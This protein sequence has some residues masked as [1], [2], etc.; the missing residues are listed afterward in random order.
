MKIKVF[1]S[2]SGDRSK[3]FGEILREWLPK[4]VHVR[5]FFSPE[6]TAKGSNWY[7]EIISELGQ[8]RIGII[9]ITSDN[10]TAPWLMFEA[11]AISK[12]LARPKVCPILFGMSATSLVGP[13]ATFQATEFA[14]DEMMRLVCMINDEAGDDKLDQKTL[15]EVFDT[16]W[17][18]LDAPVKRALNRPGKISTAAVPSRADR[19]ILEEILVRTRSIGNQEKEFK[20]R[21]YSNLGYLVGERSTQPGSLVAKDQD[22]LAEAV[23][24]CQKGWDYLKEIGGAPEFMALNNLVYYSTILNDTSKADFL[25]AQAYR[26]LEAGEQHAATHLILTG[27]FAIIRFSLVLEERRAAYS[28]ILTLSQGPLSTAQ[29]EEAELY[30][31]S[32][33]EL[34]P[35]PKRRI[36]ADK[37]LS[38]RR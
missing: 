18:K 9:C 24:H 35:K 12:S 38:K 21:L 28:K 30:L 20:G 10:L 17:P 25:L 7:S 2:W 5:P 36:S 15:A 13:L 3:V 16:W 33:L 22:L 23:G 29:R 26:L 14:R 31:K 8:A 4:V 19:E 32:F 11:G 37:R 27:S 1:I 34:G 6:D